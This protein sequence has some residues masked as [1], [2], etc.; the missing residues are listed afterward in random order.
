MLQSSGL[1]LAPFPK[2]QPSSSDH[3][4]ASLPAYLMDITLGHSDLTSPDSVTQAQTQAT[5]SSILPV[6]SSPVQRQLCV[7]SIP[8]A[9]LPL[10]TLVQD[11]DY[12]LP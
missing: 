12:L 11:D 2:L 3:Y 9:E 8:R 4:P 10:T 1:S 6:Q 7:Q 5:L